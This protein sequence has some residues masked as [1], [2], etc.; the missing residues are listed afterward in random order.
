[1][2]DCKYEVCPV[3]ELES[4]CERRV[5][6]SEDKEILVLPAMSLV[7][8]AYHLPFYVLLGGLCRQIR[9]I[10]GAWGRTH[11]KFLLL[12]SAPLFFGKF[13]DVFRKHYQDLFPDDRLLR[14]HRRLARAGRGRARLRP[15]EG[16]TNTREVLPGASDGDWM[17]EALRMKTL[18]FGTIAN[19]LLCDLPLKTANAEGKN[20]SNPRLFHQEDLLRVRHEDIIPYYCRVVGSAACNHD[21]PKALAQFALDKTVQKHRTSSSKTISDEERARII[22]ESFDY[23]ELL[24]LAP[25][26]CELQLPCLNYLEYILQ[27]AEAEARAGKAVFVILDR[28]LKNWIEK[29]PKN[30]AQ[31]P[32]EILASGADPPEGPELPVFLTPLSR[33]LNR[34]IESSLPTTYLLRVLF[35]LRSKKFRVFPEL[36]PRTVRKLEQ[37]LEMEQKRES[38]DTVLDEHKA[39]RQQYAEAIPKVINDGFTALQSQI[40]DELRY[41]M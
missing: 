34:S 15:S 9:S 2:S 22:S 24:F 1:M 3:C 14:L 30:Q 27:I 12:C 25:F 7:P 35:E 38:Y 19:V 23:A 39:I 32:Y 16:P 5:K 11:V 41:I 29:G 10:N 33:K 20:E 18:E 21:Q 8:S 26:P 6:P 4:A 40:V 28:W 13:C 31:L 36:I 17:R 37:L